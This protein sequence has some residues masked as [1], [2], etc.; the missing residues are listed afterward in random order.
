MTGL[1]AFRSIFLPTT[2]G[3]I[4]KPRTLQEDE[5]PEKLVNLTFGPVK[6]FSDKKL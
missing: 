3:A 1:R 5:E 2:G 4:L 6:L